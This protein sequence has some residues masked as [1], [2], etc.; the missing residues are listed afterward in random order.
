MARKVLNA[1][2]AVCFSIVEIGGFGTE[3]RKDE[4]LFANPQT[5]GIGLHC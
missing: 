1:V 5:Y 3:G 2:S 4:G